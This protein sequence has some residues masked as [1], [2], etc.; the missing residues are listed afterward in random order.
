M[1]QGCGAEASQADHEEIRAAAEDRHRRAS[2]LLRGDERDR[3]R[4]SARGRWPPQ[5]SGREFSSAVSI[6]KLV[7]FARDRNGLAAIELAIIAP[8]LLLCTLCVADPGRFALEKTWVTYAASAG[9]E[10]AAARAS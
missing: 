1:G 3:H 9:A 5:Q 8:V 2:G 7:R 10:Y 4:R 6:A